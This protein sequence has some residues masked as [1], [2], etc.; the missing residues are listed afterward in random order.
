[1]T[2]SSSN[3]NNDNNGPRLVMGVGMGQRRQVFL[4][5]TVPGLFCLLLVVLVPRPRLRL[6]ATPLRGARRAR[7]APERRLGD[8]ISTGKEA[9]FLATTNVVPPREMAKSFVPSVLGNQHDLC[10]A[11]LARNRSQPGTFCLGCRVPGPSAVV[12]VRF[13][14]PELGSLVGMIAGASSSSVHA[15]EQ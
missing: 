2:C 9:Q 10:Q 4:V 15:A 12:H 6:R 14:S 1:M 7:R 8:S 5:H 3:N 13:R 11:P